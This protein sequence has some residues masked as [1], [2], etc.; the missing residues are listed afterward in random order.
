M[1][2]VALFFTAGFFPLP[3]FLLDYLF[4][5]DFKPVSPLPRVADDS[6]GSLLAFGPCRG[7]CRSGV[8]S[9]RMCRCVCLSCKASE[10]TRKACPAPGTHGT[11]S[12]V[13]FQVLGVLHRCPARPGRPVRHS[14]SSVT[15]RVESAFPTCSFMSRAS[16]P[17]CR[18]E[19]GAV[20]FFGTSEKENTGEAG[21]RKLVFAQ[22]GRR[23]CG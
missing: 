4:L 22:P 3:A 8:W 7:L 9:F 6:S 10:G 16:W 13:P 11:V 14:V 20:T 19:V 5:P 15:P 12:C 17:V 1:D 23:A 2:S 21:V 18:W